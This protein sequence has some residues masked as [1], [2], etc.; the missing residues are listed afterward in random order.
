M[1]PLLELLDDELEVEL[2]VDDPDDVL[3]VDELPP[4]LDEPVPV[5]VPVASPRVFELG[6]VLFELDEPVF[7]PVASPRLFEPAGGAEPPPPPPQAVNDTTAAQPSNLTA[8]SLNENP[9]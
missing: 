2:E 6:D 9:F 4:E 3:D 1:V 5:L 8:T 7:V